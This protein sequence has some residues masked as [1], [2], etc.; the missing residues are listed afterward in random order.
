MTAPDNQRDEIHRLTELA[1]NTVDTLVGL[2]VLAL[3]R[4][5][6]GRVEMQKRLA[7]NDAVGATYAEMRSRALRQASKLDGLVTEARHTVEA[8]LNPVTGRLPG[9]ARQAATMA[10]SRF[11]EFHR[12]I[13][14][15]L[16]AASERTS[17]NGDPNPS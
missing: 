16:A 8:S 17:T 9:P 11:D 13:S 3:Q 14:Q 10:Q 4:I 1:R 7:G 15:H 6:V 5:Q 2:G 12:R